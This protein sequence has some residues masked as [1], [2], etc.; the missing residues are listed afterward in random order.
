MRFEITP[1][2]DHGTQTAADL[3]DL[4]TLRERLAEAALTGQRLH[5]R[6]R[7]RHDRPATRHQERRP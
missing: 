3:V 7:P 1:F 5:I 2:D 6:P 4:T